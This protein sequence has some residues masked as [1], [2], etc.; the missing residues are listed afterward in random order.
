[1]TDVMLTIRLPETLRDR[2]QIAL[3]KEGT[4][5][6]EYLRDIIK[7][8]CATAEAEYGAVVARRVFETYVPSFRESAYT[9]LTVKKGSRKGTLPTITI[10]NSCDATNL[11]DRSV[12]YFKSPIELLV[13]WADNASENAVK[14]L[15]TL[16]RDRADDNRDADIPVLI[17]EGDLP[18]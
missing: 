4:T 17:T 1:M 16:V 3:K 18:H 14:E 6:A 2:F 12:A 8:Y 7:A 5:A 11:S 13:A 10:L 9:Y 15:N